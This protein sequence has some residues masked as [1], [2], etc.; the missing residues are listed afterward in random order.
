MFFV[1]FF[2][3]RAL[4]RFLI[5]S[6]QIILPTS[7]SVRSGWLQLRSFSTTHQSTTKLW[8]KKKLKTFIWVKAKQHLNK[9]YRKCRKRI[10][11]HNSFQNR[12]RQVNKNRI[13]FSFS[14][15]PHCRFASSVWA[16]TSA[17]RWTRRS[18]WSLA[19]DAE[20]RF[21][22]HAGIQSVMLKC[23]AIFNYFYC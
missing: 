7:G 4:H 13:V 8:V 18:R 2:Q 6:L 15:Q 20:T 23:F 17:T 10:F 21:I 5:R 1:G 12:I 3:A 11:S 19:S 16:R 22:R 9:T 14:V